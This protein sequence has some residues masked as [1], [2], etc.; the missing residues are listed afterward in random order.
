MPRSSKRPV[1][2]RPRK[3]QLSINSIATTTTTHPTDRE[4]NHIPGMRVRHLGAAR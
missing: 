1:S 3:W 4:G 2:R